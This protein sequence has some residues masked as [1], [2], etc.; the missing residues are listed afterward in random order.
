M[1][2]NELTFLLDDLLNANT[3][4]SSLYTKFDVKRGLRNSDG[5]GVL[6]GLSR[7]SSVIGSKK[8]DGVSQPVEGDLKI[9]GVSI[10]DFVEHHLEK[11]FFNFEKI[12]FL[13]LVGRFPSEDELK[14]FSLNMAKERFLT[15][16]TIKILKDIPSKD[17]M[18]RIQIG[19][20]LLYGNDEN[21]DNLD[22]F[23]N[24]LKSIRILAKLPLIIAY[25]YLF[26]SKENPTIVESD[27]SMSQ[28]ESFL[29]ILFEGQAVDPLIKKVM[30]LSLVLHAEHGG[31]NNST[32][33]TY[34]VT[35]SGS[36]IYSTTSASVASLKGPLHGA[37]NRKVMVMMND[38]K[39]NV[40]NWE[41]EDEVSEYLRQ[42]LRKEAGDKT[43][44]IYG[45]GHAVY[46]ISDPRATIIKSLALDIAKQK[47]RLKELNLYFLIEKLGPQIFNEVK[48][49]SKVI[50][51]NVDFFSGFVYDC[52]NI[53][54]DLFTPLFAMSRCAGWCAHRLEENLSGKRIIRPGYKGI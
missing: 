41:D 14:L 52:L 5:S 4:D 17:V 33:T 32:F 27:L 22:S 1:K 10:L 21:P 16:R 15:E 24:F 48:G 29:H 44:K 13:L 2:E 43:G 53:P 34:V 9:R 46:T 28:A 45:L 30:D 25:S 51:P 37:A 23:E 12:C 3:I 50:S 20:A 6:A 7:I 54:V 38:I 47:N 31:G 40:K 26:I 39:D 42:I 18:N 8:V 36:D 35:S 19:L 11:S 49:S